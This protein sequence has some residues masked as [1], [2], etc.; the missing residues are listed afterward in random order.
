MKKKNLVLTALGLTGAAA[1]AAVAGGVA[2]FFNYALVRTPDEKEKK[3]ELRDSLASIRYDLIL[4]KDVFS[5]KVIS[6][7][8]Y[9]SFLLSRL[10]TMDLMGVNYELEKN[11][12][13]GSGD[14]FYKYFPV[15]A[16]VN[17]DDFC[18]LSNS[19]KRKLNKLI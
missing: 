18:M 6:N 14:E 9:I 3:D 16:V 17:S 5:R 10:H 4:K 12:I 13:Y 15:N 7:Y 8:E 2:Y 11:T 19:N 1:A